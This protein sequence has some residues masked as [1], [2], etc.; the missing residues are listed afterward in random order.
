M[1]SRAVDPML[2]RRQRVR[3]ATLREL[4]TIGRELL[5]KQGVEGL[6]I[7][8]V[9]REMGMTAPAVYRYFSSH[10]DLMG[11]VIVAICHDLNQYVTDAVDAVPSGAPGRRLV[12]AS[13]AL[14]RWAC[15][16]STEFQLTMIV[17][18]DP[19]SEDESVAQA[20]R[21]LGVLFG[22][23]FCELWQQKEP[24][25]AGNSGEVCRVAEQ[26][27]KRLNMSLPP[28]AASLFLRCWLRLYGIVCIES[29][30]QTRAIG[31]T[32]GA[33]FEAELRDLAQQLDLSESDLVRT[34]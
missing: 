25:V 4:V 6:T 34:R 20:R 28:N 32:H 10:R 21:S 12:T 22:A 13:R 30:G 23:L 2:T 19:R 29:M 16:H 17:P 31:D 8:A 33:L 9:A 5:T 15:R 3:D 11:A 1:E 18:A 27:C 24:P 26:L 14:H 7:R